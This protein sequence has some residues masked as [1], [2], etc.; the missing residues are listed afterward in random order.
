[1]FPIRVLIAVLLACASARAST[2]LDGDWNVSL[3]NRRRELKFTM[4]FSQV[5]GKLDGELWAIPNRGNSKEPRRQRISNLT[6]KDRT[7]RFERRFR[8]SKAIYEGRLNHRG[9]IVGKVMFGGKQ[10][11]R[12]QMTRAV[13]PVGVWKGESITGKRKFPWTLRVSWNGKSYELD[14][15]GER[16]EAEVLRF[17]CARGK[18]ELDFTLTVSGLKAKVVM[19]GAFENETTMGGPWHIDS[20]LL[21]AKGDWTAEREILSEVPGRWGVVAK[22]ADGEVK[23]SIDLFP[24]QNGWGGFYSGDL[25]KLV[26]LD[27]VKIDE[28][29]AVF[30]VPGRLGGQDVR[31]LVDA[32][33]DGQFALVGTWKVE[34]GEKT[35]EWR[36]TRQLPKPEPPVDVRGRWEGSAV[37]ANGLAL[38]LDL[39]F[40]LADGKLHGALAQNES[41]VGIEE[42][43]VRAN[44]IR[45]VWNL[46]RAK[47]QLRVEFTGNMAEDGVLTGEWK[48]AEKATG[49]WSARRVEKP[50]GPKAK[51]PPPASKSNDEKK[52]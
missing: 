4:N 40:T 44:T 10:F 16:G 3:K 36:A 2:L 43:K 11:G 23:S 38:D 19:S 12:L 34:G 25:G 14:I 51:T 50:E 35:G 42:V 31:L 52:S 37:A 45:F 18:I 27:Q 48:N 47:D 21:K 24:T 49:S 15:K 28:T 41:N 39:S 30:A 5:D 8:R 46:E 32:K 6:F 7:L 13:S 29:S 33:Y 9:Q 1:M 26:E 17:E 22:T 20:P